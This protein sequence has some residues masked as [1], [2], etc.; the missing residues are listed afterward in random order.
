MNPP[1]QFPL[2]LQREGDEPEEGGGG[3]AGRVLEEVVADLELL[4]ALETAVGVEYL[5]LRLGLSQGLQRAFAE[6]V[7]GEDDLP[8]PGVPEKGEEVVVLRKDVALIEAS[9]VSLM[10]SNLHEQLGP[11]QCADLIDFLRGAFAPDSTR[12]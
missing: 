3:L 8:A 6:P 7:G 10:P 2:R 4:P 12:R 1:P 5:L 11:Q 9:Q